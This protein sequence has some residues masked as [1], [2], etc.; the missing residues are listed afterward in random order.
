MATKMIN[1]HFI[2]DVVYK[3]KLYHAANIA[4]RNACVSLKVFHPDLQINHS[5]F[6]AVF[7]VKDDPRV[8]EVCFY[9]AED[10]TE[11]SD[12]ALMCKAI[13]YYDQGWYT[14]ATL[15]TQ[16]EDYYPVVPSTSEQIEEVNNAIMTMLCQ[17]VG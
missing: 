12:D 2:D 16:I 4:F 13:F 9:D 1:I 3:E 11:C 17:E 10:G 14:P 5:P 7:A 6:K 15:W 8:A